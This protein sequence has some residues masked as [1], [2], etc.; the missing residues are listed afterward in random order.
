MDNKIKETHQ[1]EQPSEGKALIKILIYMLNKNH[2]RK[3]KEVIST[4]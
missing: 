3:L 1:E 4:Q 2:P